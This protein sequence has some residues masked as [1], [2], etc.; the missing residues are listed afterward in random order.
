MRTTA[1]SFELQR[2]RHILTKVNA[3]APMMREM[4][5]QE[6]QAQTPRMRKMLQGGQSLNSLLPMA[7]ATAREAARRVLGMY[8]YDVQVIGA[9]VLHHGWIA[10]MKTGEGKTLT[11]ALPLYLNGLTGK[12]AILVT[13]SRYLAQRDQEELSALYEWL[14]LT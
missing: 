12:G 6:L 3:L 7:F 5:D 13:P 14:G 9:I 10:E 4:S 11:A 8:P 1:F 2:A